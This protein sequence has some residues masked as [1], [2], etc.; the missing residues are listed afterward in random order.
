MHSLLSLRLFIAGILVSVAALVC[1]VLF[2]GQLAEFYKPQFGSDLHVFAAKLTDVAKAGPYFA[3][4]VIIAVFGLA[5]SRLDRSRKLAW[6][7]I[8]RWGFQALMAFLFSGVLVQLLKHLLGRKRPYAVESLSPHEFHFMTANYE[9]H[10]MPSGH[11][12]VMFTA[13]TVLWLIWPKG[14]IVWF[15]MAALIAMTRVVT[16]NHW[17]SDI[18]V[19]AYVGFAG[20]MIAHRYFQKSDRFRVREGVLK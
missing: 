19:G 20:T 7:E 5:G 3:I 8:M 15:V 9:F 11:S 14:G 10:S 13:A 2:D 17:M 1:V 12:Q 16:L 6:A 18:L 4:S